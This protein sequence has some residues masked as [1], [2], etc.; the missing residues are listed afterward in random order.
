[1]NINLDRT[2]EPFAVN[3]YDAGWIQV[4]EHRIDEP[5]A[6]TADSV[7]TD[8]LPS[9][10]QA[11]TLMHFAPFIDTRPEIVLLGTGVRQVFVDF[12]WN[13]RGIDIWLEDDAVK[14]GGVLLPLGNP[15]PK[16]PYG[17]REPSQVY[18]D[19]LKRLKAWKEQ[20]G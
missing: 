1:M 19:V 9:E 6:L 17:G 12:A 5:C 2:D 13:P 20:R 3:A 15:G 11:L 8:N 7:I 4:G 18:A 14:L 16:I 10:P